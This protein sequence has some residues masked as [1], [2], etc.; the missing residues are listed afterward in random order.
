MKRAAL[1]V[2][3]IVALTGPTQAGQNLVWN[4]LETS[5]NPLRMRQTNGLRLIESRP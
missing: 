5:K 2:A 3:L 1:G 4:P